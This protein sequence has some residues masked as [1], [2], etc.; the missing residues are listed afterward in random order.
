M[1][2]IP[3]KAVVRM[4]G[5]IAWLALA[6]GLQMLGALLFFKTPVDLILITTYFIITFGI[7]L[8]NRFTDSEDSFNCP[9]QRIFF[10]QKSKLIIVPIFFI[11]I[12]IILL[13]ATDR[14][15]FWHIILIVLGV[16]YSV[17][18]I[19]MVHNNSMRFVRL[20]DLLFIK[21]ISV[22]LLWGI[23]PFVIAASQK[24]P[25]FPTLGDLL[26][27]VSA[28][29]LTTLINTVSC[30]V[31]DTDGDRHAGV[32]TL[33]T[34]FGEKRTG[35]L[36]SSLGILAGLLV[37]I[38]FFLG[39]VGKPATILFF[40]TIIWTGAVAVPIYIKKI[41]FPKSLSEPLIDTQQVV[42]GLSLIVLSIN[43]Q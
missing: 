36:L 21:N 37:A 16:L 15:V 9:E 34:R 11:A 30:D 4:L 25:V 12:S 28:F 6:A 35:A 42:C 13:T 27:V 41:K 10:Q 18:L 26:V 7:Y 40:S 14:L 38:D 22:S 5:P 43:I 1:E 24:S 39:N 32:L 17:N 29:C 2:T 8:L 20:K 31:R 33:A 19:P 3:F 23:T